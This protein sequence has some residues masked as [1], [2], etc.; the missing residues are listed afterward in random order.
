MKQ[1]NDST[2]GSE[3]FQRKLDLVK[4]YS[5]TELKLPQ[6][7]VQPALTRT[8]RLVRDET[9]NIFYGQTF[10]FAIF[11]RAADT[12]RFIS[13]LRALDAHIY[14]MRR[15]ILVYRKKF[16]FKQDRKKLCTRLTQQ[17]INVKPSL[18]EF[19]LLDRAY[20]FVICCQVDGRLGPER[21]I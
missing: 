13:W 12:E 7:A 1:T 19:Q 2:L 21:K 15:L 11:D 16:W 14:R 3:A 4:M 9:L 5:R 10:Q 6:T 17:G 18:I 8:S 20:P